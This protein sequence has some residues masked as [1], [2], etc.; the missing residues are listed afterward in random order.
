MREI[1]AQKSLFK[2]KKKT[3]EVKGERRQL[4]VICFVG[5]A[6]KTRAATLAWQ[7]IIAGS[8]KKKKRENKKK[9]Q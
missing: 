2:N 3:R 6:E 4:T 5:S 7:N 9:K 8:A 1:T